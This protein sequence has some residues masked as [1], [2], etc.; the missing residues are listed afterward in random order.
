MKKRKKFIYILSSVCVLFLIGYL[1]CFMNEKQEEKDLANHV[2]NL[3][4]NFEYDFEK[5]NV[6]NSIPLENRKMPTKMSFSQN[7]FYFE[8][9]EQTND[10]MYVS[11]KIF[12]YDFEQNQ[13]NKVLEI[14]EKIKMIGSIEINNQLLVSYID[15]RNWEK[16]MPYKYVVSTYVDGKEVVL[17]TT[18]FGSDLLNP[19]FTKSNN[20][21]YFFSSSIDSK[22][23]EDYS[24]SD[25]S[26]ILYSFDGRNLEKVFQ[27]KS[28]LTDYTLNPEIP[29][30]FDTKIHYNANN[31]IVFQ[32]LSNK[33]GILHILKDNEIKNIDIDSKFSLLE[34]MANY[35][36]LYNIDNKTFTFY[37]FEKNDY[38]DIEETDN[39]YEAI[40][41]NDQYICV[42]KGD[43]KHYLLSPYNTKAKIVKTPVED[44]DKQREFIY[45]DGRN[46]LL[47]I[48]D[49]ETDE[50]IFYKMCFNQ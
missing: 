33:Q 40:N 37:D 34:I 7:N 49:Y 9:F 4:Q 18:K 11:K 21:V 47:Q 23:N 14:D 36:L 13:V 30:I 41:I 48:S 39:M 10:L 32:E 50:A 28:Y 38:H 43:G 12:K 24:N 25:I 15:L 3:S 16:G 45:S 19:N 35:A 8:N 17:L 5:I 29:F 46:V 22:E 2:P 31:E 26:V 42:L 1:L 6:L 20:K 44:Y 27:S